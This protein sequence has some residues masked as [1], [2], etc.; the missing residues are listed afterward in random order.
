MNTDMLP[1]GSFAVWPGQG[2]VRVEGERDVSV[3]GS[4]ATIHATD[5]IET[6]VRPLVTHGEA[7]QLVAELKQ[8]SGNPDL[9]AFPERFRDGMATLVRR[10]LAQQVRVLHTLY[11]APFGLSLPEREFMDS[12]ERVVVGELAH[13]L[14]KDLDGELLPELHARQPA[15]AS[16][17]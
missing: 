3:V 17:G 1:P 5:G 16:A 8:A 7:E 13:V 10:P 11:R 15:F 12:L 2:V 4:G 6:R 9:R 14:G